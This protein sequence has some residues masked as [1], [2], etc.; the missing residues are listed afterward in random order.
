MFRSSC[1]E[2]RSP[3]DRLGWRLISCAATESKRGQRAPL[4]SP[5]MRAMLL[6]LRLAEFDVLARHR[7]VLLLDHLVGHGAR[8]LLGDVI[9]ARIRRGN[10]LDL[11]SDRFGHVLEPSMGENRVRQS[12]GRICRQPSLDPSKVKVSR[13]NNRTNLSNYSKNRFFGLGRPRFSRSVMP[14]YSRRKIPRF[15]SSGPTLWTKSPRPAG[16]NGNMILKPSQ[17]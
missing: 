14:S 2:V 6:D 7:I 11:D 4:N 12:A 13:A 15:C 8:I 3:G 9:E 17:P 10:E 1:P 16:R 5:A